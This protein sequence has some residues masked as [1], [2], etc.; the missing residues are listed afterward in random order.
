MGLARSVSLIGR[1][2]SFRWSRENWVTLT[3][4]VMSEFK[5]RHFEGEIIL[6]AVRWYCRYGISYRDL[7]QMMGERG[8]GVD[9]S[10]V[11]RW[12]QKYAPEMVSPS[13]NVRKSLERAKNTLVPQTHCLDGGVQ[14][15]QEEI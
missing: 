8:V 15:N 6:W 11:Y 10:T 12:V 2:A 1:V 7:E 4:L 13:S 9:H 3:E 14:L 5:W